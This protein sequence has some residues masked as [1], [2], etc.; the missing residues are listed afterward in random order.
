MDMQHYIDLFQQVYKE[1]GTPYNNARLLDVQVIPANTDTHD[2]VWRLIGVHHLT[3]VENGGKHHIYCDV[4]DLHG[5]RINGMYLQA[6]IGNDAHEAVIDKPLEEPGTNF[7]MWGNG[8]PHL[9]YVPKE[10]FVDGYHGIPSDSVHGLHTLWPDEDIGNTRG[11]HSFLC[12]WQ[13][14]IVKDIPKSPSTEPLKWID[15]KAYDSDYLYFRIALDDLID[16]S[17]EV[18]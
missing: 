7:P 5:N 13:F 6:E 2:Y 12:I 3:G 1:K 4:L 14:M 15:D 8:E 18:G 16:F 10:Q 11:H 17:K 9:V